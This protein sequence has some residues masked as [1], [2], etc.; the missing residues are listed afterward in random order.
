VA[1]FLFV[2]GAWHGAWC[3]QF[4]VEELLRRGHRAEAVD[5]PCE[6]VG[7]TQRDYATLIGPQPDAIVVGHSLGAQTV[8]LVEARLRV[9]VA[10]LLPV[11]DAEPACFA[12]GF[13]GAVRDEL[14]RSY[15]PDADTCA[16]RLYPDCT[17]AQSDWAFA[18]LRR[19]ARI[20]AR[21]AP[22]G[23]GDVVI[24]TLRDSAIDPGWQVGTAK[25]YGARVVE[26]DAGHS[27]FLTQPEELA[28]VLTS[29]A[30]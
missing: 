13:G 14:D 16:A 25:M 7:L 15:W 29:L 30:A 23:R 3:F 9:Y 10:G 19:Q 11:E 18:Q 2:H 24:A 4:V 12:P 27:P 26:L 17:R 1:R 28:E 6:Q 20:T 22:F 5:L 21:A 8:P